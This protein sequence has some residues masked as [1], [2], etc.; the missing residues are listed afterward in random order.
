MEKARSSVLQK[1][2]TERKS[3]TGKAN[4]I[5]STVMQLLSC[6]LFILRVNNFKVRS[7][8]SLLNTQ[9]CFVRLFITGTELTRGTMTLNRNFVSK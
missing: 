1:E 3:V 7:N 4:V 9:Y 8:L 2:Y 5:K 6:C